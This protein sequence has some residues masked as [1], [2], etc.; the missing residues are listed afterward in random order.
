MEL[1]FN[2]TKIADA[3]GGGKNEILFEEFTGIQKSDGT[4]PNDPKFEYFKKK[5][6]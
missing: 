2:A 6:L 3:I 5:I 1:V 4:N